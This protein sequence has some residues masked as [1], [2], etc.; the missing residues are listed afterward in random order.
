MPRK[1]SKDKPKRTPIREVRKLVRSSSV[2][3]TANR[4]RQVFKQSSLY[5]LQCI[6]LDANFRAVSIEAW[7]AILD[8][9]KIDRYEYQADTRD[10]DNFAA[11]MHGYIPL[12][13]GVNTAGYVVD[14]SGGHAY[15]A[16]VCYD[17][18]PE[19]L[20]IAVIEPQTDGWV[21]VGDQMSVSEFYKAEQG[22]VIWG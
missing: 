13:L 2:D 22:F 7:R 9:S 14:I 3:L 4:L 21:T 15:N 1:A 5:R 20:R 8:W 16:V 6:A 17:S 12:T 10:C 19:D 18:D 11:A